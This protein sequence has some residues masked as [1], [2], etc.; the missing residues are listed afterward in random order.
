MREEHD[1]GH[2]HH[3]HHHH[4]HK[5]PEPNDSSGDER[6]ESGLQKLEDW[7]RHKRGHHDKRSH[8]DPTPKLKK[9][10][11]VRRDPAENRG[12]SSGDDEASDLSGPED[13]QPSE[14]D[15]DLDQGQPRSEHLLSLFCSHTSRIKPLTLE[16][17][18]SPLPDNSG[19]SARL[20][21]NA[22]NATGRTS[23]P[24]PGSGWRTP[25]DE[26][27]GGELS[28]RFFVR[29][30]LALGGLT[31]PRLPLISRN[32]FRFRSVRTGSTSSVRISR[33]RDRSHARSAS[34]AAAGLV[35]S[36]ESAALP[37]SAG[38]ASLPT[39]HE[40][41]VHTAGAS[42]C[43]PVQDG[44]ALD[45]GPR[46]RERPLDPSPFG[47]SSSG[48]RCSCT[49]S[50]SSSGRRSIHSEHAAGAAWPIRPYDLDLDLDLAAAGA[51]SPRRVHP[52]TG[53]CR[54]SRDDDVSRSDVFPLAAGVVGLSRH[55][56]RSAA[57][58]VRL[59][60]RD[61]LSPGAV[62]HD[63]VSGNVVSACSS[64][65]SYAFVLGGGAGVVALA[66][67]CSFRSYS[68]ESALGRT[69]HERFGMASAG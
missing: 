56:F 67:A 31:H 47:S 36:S 54:L 35:H 6:D 44:S 8:S 19:L 40:S 68:E 27:T 10:E 17:L 16:S 62:C 45:R 5:L 66:L 14:P 57:G 4:H 59:C 42:A 2:H 34:S 69:V 50:S 18:P 38:S 48:E 52:A 28:L 12:G 9:H 26:Q 60:C 43:L 7:W 32:R 1:I 33:S 41:A 25:S 37:A 49:G 20:T 51:F 65:S 3:H 13:D 24:P 21:S 29:S 39:L 22:D 30:R 58:V 64:S 46:T 55:A 15:S 61:D 23:A 11:K 63:V 53:V